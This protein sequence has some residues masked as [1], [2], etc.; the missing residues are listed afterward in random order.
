MPA[1]GA[2]G[3]FP[4]S[5]LGQSVG[6]IRAVQPA[7]G[8]LK[9]VADLYRSA[10]SLRTEPHIGEKIA[11]E[12]SVHC[13][14]KRLGI[15]TWLVKFSPVLRQQ[16]GQPPRLCPGGAKIQLPMLLVFEHAGF[17]PVGAQQDHR[18][19][20][21]TF[22]NGAV[23]HVVQVTEFDGFVDQSHLILSL[24]SWPG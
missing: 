7:R 21:I 9:D 16:I 10:K 18:R 13:G 20:L 12:P 1:K 11:L 6:R 17:V 2:F 14:M 22:A 4:T 8:C 3:T 23:A 5:T 15:V 19:M 24:I